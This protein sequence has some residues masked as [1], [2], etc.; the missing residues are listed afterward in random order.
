MKEGNLLDLVKRA[1]YRMEKSCAAFF[2]SKV[3]ICN[4]LRYL[5]DSVKRHEAILQ[6]DMENFVKHS[7]S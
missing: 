1:P 3:N 5:S 7:K 4:P 6:Q 2:V